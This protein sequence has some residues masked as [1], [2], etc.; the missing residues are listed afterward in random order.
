MLQKL[1]RILK[2]ISGLW[3]IY[4]IRRFEYLWKH[5]NILRSKPRRCLEYAIFPHF[6][7]SDEFKN[8]LFIGVS[9]CTEHYD[10]YFRKKTFHTIDI[11]PERAK[12]GSKKRHIIDSAERVAKYFPENSL[13]AVIMNGVY[14][15]GL[16]DEGTLV[17]TI[18]GIK[19]ILRPGGVFVFGWDKVPK[20]D[21]I[22]IE[23]KDF[24]VGFEPYRIFGKTRIELDTKH[25]HI[26]IFFRKP[27]KTRG[28]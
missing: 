12:Y 4:F 18:E 9:T 24:F 19:K 1:R 21:P 6:Y 2:Y 16:D 17:K 13:D 26:Y 23:K 25:R 22:D 20:Y 27:A 28:N 3:R 14:G 15:W 10:D 8:M 11:D 5:Y 7:A